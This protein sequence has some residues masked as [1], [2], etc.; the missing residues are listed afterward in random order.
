MKDENASPALRES[1]SPQSTALRAY[2]VTAYMSFEGKDRL[3]TTYTQPLLPPLIDLRAEPLMSGNYLCEVL[4]AAETLASADAAARVAFAAAG[5]EVIAYASTTPVQSRFDAAV[6]YDALDWNALGA[7][8][9][10]ATPCPRCA[11]RAYPWRPRWLALLPRMEPKA[12]SAASLRLATFAH[13]PGAV[14]LE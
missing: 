11:S 6:R 12:H 14:F 1:R 5:V 8:P 4:V 7:P 10:A 3:R 9:I 13:G 2:R